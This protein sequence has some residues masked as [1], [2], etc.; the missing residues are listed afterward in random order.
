MGKFPLRDRF[1]TQENTTS[2]P[3]TEMVVNSLI[4]SHRDGADAE[5]WQSRSSVGMA[6]DSE[7]GTSAVQVST[8]GGKTWSTAALGQDLGRFAFPAIK[9]SASPKK[10]GGTVM[11]DA[12]NKLGPKPTGELI[13][14][15]AA[16][17]EQREVER[18]AQ[19]IR[20]GSV[21]H[22]C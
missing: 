3:I 2:T 10:N 17:A 12:I 11:V 13:F 14:N 16:H 4:T 7:Y 22:V 9:V 6:W 21:R 8:D 1:I 15:P 19:R 5:C 20:E 18:H